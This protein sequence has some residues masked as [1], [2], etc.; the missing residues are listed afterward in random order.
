M[1]RQCQGWSGAAGHGHRIGTGHQGGGYQGRGP[2]RAFVVAPGQRRVVQELTR[3]ETRSDRTVRGGG[4]REAPVV[5]HAGRSDQRPRRR[6]G[7][8]EKDLPERVQRYAALAHGH[9]RPR[10]RSR[11]Q[12]RGQGRAR[13]WRDRGGGL[14]DTRCKG[15]ADD[16]GRRDLADD[17]HRVHQ[18]TETPASTAHASTALMRARRRDENEDDCGPPAPGSS[19]ISA[20]SC[21]RPSI[22]KARS[23]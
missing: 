12:G 3:F 6:A 5:G 4:Q 1:T 22:T 7:R 10:P 2:A 21:P 13:S 14:G 20:R 8:A 17:R 19:S 9:Y 11:G 16:T 23:L 15:G 18:R